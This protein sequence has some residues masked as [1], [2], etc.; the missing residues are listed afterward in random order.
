MTTNKNYYPFKR[1]L[2]AKK[3]FSAW[4]NY[5]CKHG[6]KPERIIK[7][8][9]NGMITLYELI[10]ALRDIEREYLQTGVITWDEYANG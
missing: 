10:Q 4:I 5:L 2:D 3:D 8:Y 1:T 6:E 7:S 9:E